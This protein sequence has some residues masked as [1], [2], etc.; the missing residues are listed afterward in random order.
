M[1]VL[2]SLVHQLSVFKDSVWSIMSHARQIYKSYRCNFFS[3]ESST[4]FRL[5]FSCQKPRLHPC[6]SGF[7]MFNLLELSYNLW[8]ILCFFFFPSSLSDVFATVKAL[9]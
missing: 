5:V 9:A 7:D 3:S 8:V 1:R 2:P 4:L 6:I